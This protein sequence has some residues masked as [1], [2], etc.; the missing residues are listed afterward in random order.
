MLALLR[1]PYVLLGAL[2]VLLMTFAGG[3]KVGGDYAKGRA[4]REEVL[5]AKAGE[6]ASQAAAAAISKI[7]VV[8][9]TNRTRIER[10]IVKVPD[11][12]ACHAGDT[13][14]GVLDDALAGKAGA[15]SASGS[16]VPGA[17]PAR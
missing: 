9:Q 3:V 4:A 12:S 1:N 2:V 14:R 17:D 15:D 5:I 11:L 16:V 13:L 7:K 8:N 6:K 10:E